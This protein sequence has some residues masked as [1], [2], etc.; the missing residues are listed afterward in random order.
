METVVPDTKLAAHAIGPRPVGEGADGRRMISQKDVV[1]FKKD[2]CDENAIISE[3]IAT[4]L[5][6][7]AEEPILDVGCGMGDIAERAFPDKK[8]LLLD[9]LDY[10]F[11]PSRHRRLQVDF[12]AYHPQPEEHA[13]TLLFS[14]VQQFIDEDISALLAKVAALAPRKIITVSNVNEGALGEIVR[15][16]EENLR[17]CNAEKEIPGFPPGYQEEGCWSFEGHL[18]CPDFETLT[19][20]VSYLLATDLNQQEEETLTR[21][22][23]SRLQEPRL[24]ITQQVKAYRVMAT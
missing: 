6:D 9:R 10:S 5:G 8:V 4:H 22:L 7:W 17:Q 21:F 13:Q 24:P 14:H 18:A 2:Y 16:G 11:M 23:K 15:W 1:E 3:I 20:Q 12:F 19:R